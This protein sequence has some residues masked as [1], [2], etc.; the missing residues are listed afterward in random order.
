VEGC[1]VVV[2]EV[3]VG[4]VVAA[5]VRGDPPDG[6]VVVGRAL[7]SVVESTVVPEAALEIARLSWKSVS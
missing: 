2:V 3:V 7:P 5:A 6:G 1:G 4:V